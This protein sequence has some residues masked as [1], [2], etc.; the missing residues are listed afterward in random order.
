MRRAYTQLLLIMFAVLTIHSSILM[1]SQASNP[2]SGTGIGIRL[3]GADFVQVNYTIGYAVVVYNLGDYWVR[4]ATMTDRFP[5]GTSSSWIVPVLSPRGQSGDSFNVSSILYTVRDEDVVDSDA[6]PKCSYVINHAETSGY[7]DVHGF[8]LPV[9]AE[10]NYITFVL[11]PVGGYSVSIK[12]KGASTPT[13]IY[14]VL[15]V[16]FAAAL[17]VTGAC[18]RRVYRKGKTSEA[19]IH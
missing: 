16:T 15:L 1:K 10:T 5:N 4:N 8:K 6:P 13:T 9:K 11:V 17:P 19:L 2:P 12:T 18:R 7:S 3:D 14:A